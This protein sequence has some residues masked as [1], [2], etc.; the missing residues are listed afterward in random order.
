VGSWWVSW[1]RSIREEVVLQ[2]RRLTEHVFRLD[3]RKK[4]RLKQEDEVVDGHVWEAGETVECDCLL[5]YI[6][7]SETMRLVR[8]NEYEEGEYIYY[9][10]ADC[11]A[12]PQGVR[13]NM[14]QYISGIVL[15]LEEDV[16]DRIQRNEHVSEIRGADG[17]LVDRWP[18]S[19]DDES[20]EY[21]SE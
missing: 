8:G 10:E 9:T 21:E 15:E 16:V 14:R 18:R 2:G 11:T 3:A 20:S 19:E 1:H 4:H 6:I 17:T 7:P 5:Q 12:G 13:K